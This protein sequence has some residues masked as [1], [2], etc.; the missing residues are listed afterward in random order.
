MLNKGFGR[1][2]KTNEHASK[3]LK[4]LFSLPL[5]PEREIE[6]GFLFIKAHAINH[7]V[8]MENLFDYYQR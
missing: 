8:H 2:V 7:G 6:R 3:T 1:L 5:L 4:L